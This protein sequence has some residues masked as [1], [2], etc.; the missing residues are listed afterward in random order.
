MGSQLDKLFLLVKWTVWNSIVHSWVWVWSAISS[1]PSLKVQDSLQSNWSG[2]GPRGG[3]TMI[4][5][6]SWKNGRFFDLLS[7]DPS[8]PK[9]LT[10]TSQLYSKS[11]P[12]NRTLFSDLELDIGKFRF[13][14]F[15]D[16]G[17]LC[18]LLWLLDIVR[19]RVPFEQLS[20]HVIL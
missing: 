6:L 16:F 8:W 17:R 11:I 13:E 3:T 10:G 5:M 20:M 12:A 2:S 19:V 7:G 18:I 1:C 9:F 15:R 14:T 4:G